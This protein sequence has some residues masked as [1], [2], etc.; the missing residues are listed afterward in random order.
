MTHS[1]N[2][3]FG[4]LQVLVA[5]ALQDSGLLVDRSKC[6]AT[7]E[8]SEVNSLTL[9]SSALIITKIFPVTAVVPSFFRRVFP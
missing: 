6:R 4:F 7:V 2:V 8:G 5:L 9:R 1:L 3:V